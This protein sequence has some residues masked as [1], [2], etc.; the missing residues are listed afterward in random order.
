MDAK[1]LEA[2]KLGRAKA[3][4]RRKNNV[5]K[6]PSPLKAIRAKCLDCSETAKV[7]KYC[8]CDGVN[9]TKCDLWPFRFGT[10]PASAADRSGAQFLDPKQMPPVNTPLDTLPP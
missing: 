5:V 9:S 1:H 6:Y 3:A 10:K 8:P 7:V 2:M 4:K